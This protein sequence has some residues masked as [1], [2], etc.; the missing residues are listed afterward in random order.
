MIARS[1]FG[2]A[3]GRVDDYRNEFRVFA[4]DLESIGNGGF[5]SIAQEFGRVCFRPSLSMRTAASPPRSFAREKA[6]SR[7]C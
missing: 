7:I 2:E 3:L 1:D 6:S 4:H 5:G